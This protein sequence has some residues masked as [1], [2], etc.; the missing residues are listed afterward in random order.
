M[1]KIKRGLVKAHRK[2]LG[3][4][5][6]IMITTGKGGLTKAEIK[7]VL[8]TLHTAREQGQLSALTFEYKPPIPI[9]DNREPIFLI[10]KDG[11]VLGARVKIREIIRAR[12]GTQF[13]V[14]G[15]KVSSAPKVKVTR[16]RTSLPSR[17]APRIT[18]KTPRLRR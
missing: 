4:P 1:G 3:K 2:I 16:S 5:K 11:N 12:Y 10:P 6:D 14:D 7:D 8:Q 9:L 18:K 17:K 15:G 13:T